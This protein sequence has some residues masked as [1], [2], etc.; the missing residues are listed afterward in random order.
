MSCQI[1]ISRVGN[2]ARAVIKVKTGTPAPQDTKVMGK[3][4]RGASEK[5]SALD[6]AL[7]HPHHGRKAPRSS[8]WEDRSGWPSRDR[9]AA[10]GAAVCHIIQSALP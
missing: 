7:G 9:E 1:S 5:I 4:S 3:T 10:G 8:L 6:A 2:S